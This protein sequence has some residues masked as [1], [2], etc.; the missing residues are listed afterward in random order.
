M[1]EKE[2]YE[3]KTEVKVL[4]EDMQEVKRELTN[5]SHFSQDIALLGQTVSNLSEVVGELKTTV[6]KMSEKPEKRMETII[7][8]TLT[9]IVGL[10][11]G[12]MASKFL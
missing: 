8:S 11:I 5:Q 3:I 1:E 4:R 6:Q 9:T 7:T 10:V 2:F 12:Y